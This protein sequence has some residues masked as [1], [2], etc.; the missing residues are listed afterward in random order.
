MAVAIYWRRRGGQGEA[1]AQKLQ[2]FDAPDL[3]TTL[4]AMA[5]A[6]TQMPAV[7]EALCEAAAQKLQDFDAPGLATTLWAM[8]TAGT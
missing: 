5:T 7:F 4:W 3:A 8:A 1:A 6:G 2:D